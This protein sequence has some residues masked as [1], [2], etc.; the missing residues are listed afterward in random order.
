M[1]RGRV[2]R[3][4]ALGVGLLLCPLLSGC[5]V[6]LGAA[7]PS[8]AVTPPVQ[9]NAE[10]D[11]VHAFRV[12]VVKTDAVIDFH[13]PSVA[14]IREVPVAAR[15]WVVPQG[16][17]ACDYAWYW[18]CIALTYWKA[19]RHTVLLRLYRPGCQT[20]E[21]SAWTLPRDVAWRGVADLAGQEKA[22]DDLIT[23]GPP[24]FIQDALERGDDKPSL[25]NY[26]LAAGSDSPGH[27][28]ALLFA[29][30]EYERLAKAAPDDSASR[31]V[32]DRMKQKAAWLRGLAEK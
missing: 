26:L 17:A 8:V 12:E 30:A 2:V 19:K 6:P 28:K 7:W 31:T 24:D 25:C 18:N 16:E 20:V 15:G 27:R 1:R 3:W 29:A 23:P 14:T 4:A 9:V 11:Q 10:A 22:V 21:V 5:F 32:S 13:E